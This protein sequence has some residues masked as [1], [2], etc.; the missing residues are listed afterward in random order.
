MDT[1]FENNCTWRDVEGFEGFYAVNELGKVLSKHNK[2][3]ILNP[4]KHS[5]GYLY[6]N[7]YSPTKKRRAFVHRL[8]LES[9]SPTDNVGLEVNHIDGN[10]HNNSLENLEW[11]TPRENV[12]HARENDL[13][14]QVTPVNQY[15]LNGKF[16]NSFPS[17]SKASEST[18]V[19]YSVIR[20]AIRGTHKSAGGFLWRKTRMVNSDLVITERISGTKNNEKPVMQ[21]SKDGRFLRRFKSIAEASKQTGIGYAAVA[22]CVS[23]VNRTSGGYLW[24]YDLEEENN[25]AN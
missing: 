23:G 9:F 3:K 10:K 7:L 16:L 25:D 20:G 15:T 12:K 22:K 6:V 14:T 24:E 8:V 19:G 5:R 2:G 4:I 1:R 13:L 17:I 21:F 18:E 11:V